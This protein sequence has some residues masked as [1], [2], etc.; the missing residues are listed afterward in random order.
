MDNY[1]PSKLKLSSL[2]WE[3]V[4]IIPTGFSAIFCPIALTYFWFSWVNN[5]GSVTGM[6]W[7]DIAIWAVGI[8]LFYISLLAGIGQSGR[9]GGK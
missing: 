7:L 1:D 6:R 5:V 2:I 8:I 4:K 3:Y 9:K